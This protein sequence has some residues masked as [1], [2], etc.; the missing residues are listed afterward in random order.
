MSKELNAISFFKKKKKKSLQQ[1][2]LLR[3]I[4]FSSFK[5]IKLK[6]IGGFLKYLTIGH[7]CI[8]NYKRG[9]DIEIS[10]LPLYNVFLI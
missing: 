3:K 10:S 1:N 7:V 8:L 6:S 2:V 4:D 5:V 9:K